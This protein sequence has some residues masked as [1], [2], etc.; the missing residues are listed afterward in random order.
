[1]KKIRLLK[2]GEIEVRVQSIKE[3]NNAVGCVLLL[4]K[5]ARVD[6]KILDETFGITGWRRTH[7]LI[8]GNLFCNID[9]WDDEKK[10]WV[11]K[12]D[13]GVESY[14]EKEKGQASDSFKRAGF[15]IGI[16]REL[17]TAPFIWINLTNG[18]VVQRGSNLS[19]SPRLNFK[20]K[21]ID[22]NDSREI[23]SLR[24][25]DNNHRIRYSM[26]KN[27]EEKVSPKN[28]NKCEKCGI[29]ITENV[30][31]YSKSK[32]GHVLCM[33]CQKSEFSIKR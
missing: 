5:D 20:V 25:E 9:I 18:E 1:M 26:G 13:V 33:N 3:I 17:Y 24:I 6:M 11:R 28:N 12:Q 21:S 16:G 19:L 10:E 23:S 2:A 14:T 8:N 22:Y 27:T 15:N 32:F 31:N 4:Y 30:A 7:E 29:E